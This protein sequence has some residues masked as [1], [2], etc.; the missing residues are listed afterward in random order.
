MKKKT[1]IFLLS[2]FYILLII[3][4]LSIQNLSFSPPMYPNLKQTATCPSPG[5]PGKEGLLFLGRS[6][7]S[8]VDSEE[9][10]KEIVANM[11]T[12]CRGWTRQMFDEWDIKKSMHHHTL[13]GVV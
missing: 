3:L 11:G 4:I 13:K 9:K 8:C 2:I 10:A 7:F 12:F 5:I 6:D 1:F